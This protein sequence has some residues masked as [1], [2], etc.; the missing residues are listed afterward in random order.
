MVREHVA[1]RCR[2]RAA[3]ASGSRPA[4]E[5]SSRRSSVARF[6]SAR[7]NSGVDAISDPTCERRPARGADRLERE[8]RMV[9]AAEP[10]P[11][12][13]QHRHAE[14][15][16]QIARI[17][18]RVQRDTPAAGAFDDRPVA[19]LRVAR[20]VPVEQRSRAVSRTPASAAARCGAMAGSKQIGIDERVWHAR[21]RPSACSASASRIAQ[22]VAACAHAPLASGFRPR[23]RRPAG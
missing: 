5:H 2:Y 22:A 21:G 11:D 19:I 12:D 6:S 16:G 8:P 3:K 1:P 13:E 14:R 4:V 23:A 9:Q 10:H 20:F 17:S 15:L 18:L 7:A